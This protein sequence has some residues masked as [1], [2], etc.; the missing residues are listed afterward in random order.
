MDRFGEL[1]LFG[2][3]LI[4]S[5]FLKRIVTSNFRDIYEEFNVRCFRI[6]NMLFW[7]PKKGQLS[8]RR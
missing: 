1:S 7:V 6:E 5:H 2:R 4:P 3:Y 8:E